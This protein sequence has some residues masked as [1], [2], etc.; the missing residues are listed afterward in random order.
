[1]SAG[2]QYATGDQW[3]NNSGNTEDMRDRSE[4]NTT[5]SCRCDW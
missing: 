2:A 4:T 5:P 1:M 3:R